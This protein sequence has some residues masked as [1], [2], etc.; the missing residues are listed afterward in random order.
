MPQE[1][2]VQ[3]STADGRWW[4][5]TDSEALSDLVF[6]AARHVDD[7]TVDRQQRILNAY[8]Q[9]G[10][11]SAWPGG[12]GNMSLT[13]LTGRNRVS[14]NVI[15]NA[16][17]S[18]V[19]EVTQTQ[20]RPMAVTNG[21]DYDARERAEML[22]HWW[23]AEFDRADVRA[24]APQVVRDA[25][26]SGLG[27]MRPYIDWEYNCVRVERIHPLS[28]LVDD[29][30]CV[31]VY[32]R[33]VYLRRFV[34]KWHFLRKVEADD[35]LEEDERL[36]LMAAIEKAPQPDPAY[37]TFDD[38]RTNTIEIIEAWHLP[39]TAC[40][41]DAD[42]EETD[43]RHVVVLHGATYQQR[44]YTRER[45]PL[46]VMRPVPPQRGFWGESLVERATPTQTELN[47]L[48]RRIQDAM[49][50][51]AV[52][53]VYAQ[54]G[55]INPAYMQNDVGVVIPFTGTPPQ[56]ITPPSMSND[57]Y[58]M[59]D[60]YTAWIYNEMGV[61][62][63]G[64]T[65]RKEPGLNSGVAIRTVNK[66]QS[67][68]FISF[69][70]SYEE[71]HVWL[72][73]EMVHHMRELD[74][75]VNG[76]EVVYDD[77]EARDI[78]Q[79]KEIHLD[80][81]AY[82]VRV[83]PASALSDSPAVRL[84]QV[85]ELVNAGLATPEDAVAMLPNADFKA[86]ANRVQAP[87]KLLN[88]IFSRMLKDE[89]YRAPEPHMNLPLGIDVCKTRLQEADL[90]DR[91]E[92][93]LELLRNWITDAAKLLERAEQA[94]AE[95]AAANA[96]PPMPPMPDGP[97]PPMPGGPMPPGEMPMVGPPMMPGSEGMPANEM[98]P[99]EMIPAA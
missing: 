84:E 16:V 9:Y 8:C 59:V 52:P 64:A 6:R 47:K 1:E 71:A 73:E 18:L 65:S 5:E 66:L 17:D 60:R 46:P 77:G 78:I 92:E 74:E 38:Y 42:L 21:G 83:F 2:P 79:W 33:C 82:R 41:P 67:K 32:P 12:A 54:K 29:V 48:L 30:G 58:Q 80:E 10:D 11:A 49:H 45:F 26:V 96:P 44:T 23:D 4:N 31:D 88:R 93:H 36:L 85:Q 37:W 39:S 94:A 43:G 90:D 51:H 75:E 63:M 27:I 50:L 76:V 34:N 53:R 19:S 62:E 55:S 28:V 68:R 24:I 81:D 70:R 89:V 91:P 3:R 69:E 86:I 57:V 72:A 7:A 56:H 98:M 61:S 99:P 22:T 40:D 13:Y 25:V 15:A 87:K 97:M 20:P 35:T 95:E 14:H